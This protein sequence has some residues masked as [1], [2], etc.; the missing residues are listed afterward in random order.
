[1]INNTSEQHYKIGK[2]SHQ[3]QAHTAG[4]EGVCSRA[5]GFTDSGSSVRFQKSA[6]TTCDIVLIMN[7]QVQNKQKTSQ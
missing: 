5:N 7:A 3:A 4:T 1:M 2:G 6:H